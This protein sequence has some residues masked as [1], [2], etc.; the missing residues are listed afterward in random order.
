MIRLLLALAAISLLFT[1]CGNAQVNNLKK[2]MISNPTT[3]EE[4]DKN[5]ILE[6]AI[7]NNLDAKSTPSGIYYVMEKEGD[8]KGS[9]TAADQVTAHYH[10]TLLDGT[11]FDSSVDRGQPFSFSLGGVIRGWQEAIPMLSRGGKGKFM[12]PS[13]LAYGNRAA[14]PVIKPNSP[15]VFDIELIDFKNT[16]AMKAEQRA[17]DVKLIEEFATTNNLK[18]DK[19]EKG[20][21]YVMEKKGTGNENPKVTSK[22][23]VHYHGTLLDGTVFDS[24][25]DRGEP[26]EFGLNQ[27]IPGWQDAIPLLTVGGKGKFIIPSD[28][29]Y[30]SRP[31]GKIPANSVL[32]FDVELLGIK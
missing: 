26:I 13:G 18:L 19:T 4:K 22:V 24:S 8:G 20:V 16:E 29:A 3:Q 17:K 15:L 2:E 11:V 25:V 7:A 30:G 14:G 23:K 28:L 31:A 6:Y 32:I 12:I 10:G 27:V 1:S 5:A 21:Y 9:P